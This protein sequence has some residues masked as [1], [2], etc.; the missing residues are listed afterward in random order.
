MHVLR[1]R[2]RLRALL[3]LPLLTLGSLIGTL[4]AS[5]SPAH[6]A[7]N[8][9]LSVSVTSNG[10]G[11]ATVDAATGHVA[12][13]GSVPYL[14]SPSGANGLYVSISVTADGQGYVVM[15]STGQMYAYGTADAFANPPASAYSYVGVSLSGDGHGWAAVDS[16]GTV[17]T[18]GNVPNLGNAL[19]STGIVGISVRSSGAG[20]VAVSKTG[21]IYAHGVTYRTPA[22]YTHPVAGISVNSTGSGYMVMSNAGELYAYGTAITGHANPP[23]TNTM[24]S[25]AITPNGQGALA[26]STIGQM[27]AYNPVQF[28]GNAVPGTPT[29]VETKAQKVV[30]YSRWAAANG[31]FSGVPANLAWPANTPIPYVLGGGHGP[32]PGPTGGG[33]DCG[34]FTRWMYALATGGDPLSFGLAAYQEDNPNFTQVAAASAIPGDLVVFTHPNEANS[35][36]V[37]IYIGAGQMIDALHTGTFVEYDPIGHATDIITYFHFTG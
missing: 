11:Y 29:P 28:N 6:A 16:H 3:L 19:N 23:V 35:H 33:V 32:Q 10:T 12:R 34:G 26:M 14:G 27:Y 17:T 15:S 24:T 31:G 1:H 21:Q 9:Y 2:S 22:T 7:Q 13:F 4:F 5:V 8:V 18:R 36:H 20:Y 37:G 30:D 25:V